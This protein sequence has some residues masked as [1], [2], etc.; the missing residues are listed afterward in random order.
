[1]TSI[2]RKY[3]YELPPQ[4]RDKVTV[5]SKG[6]GE[7]KLIFFCQLNIS[8]TDHDVHGCYTYVELTCNILVLVKYWLHISNWYF[9]P[10][11]SLPLLLHWLCPAQITTFPTIPFVKCCSMLAAKLN[12]TNI[13]DALGSGQLVVSL[14]QVN[15]VIGL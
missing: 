1:M 13:G 2:I 4:S 3:E 14:L 5:N 9:S 11:P 12:S 10:D 7:F 8:L 6:V 15:V